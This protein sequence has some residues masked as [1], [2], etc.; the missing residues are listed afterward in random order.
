[1]IS[2]IGVAHV[3]FYLAPNFPNVELQELNDD[4]CGKVWYNLFWLYVMS[5][6]P[7]DKSNWWSPI[8][9]FAAVKSFSINAQITE[10]WCVQNP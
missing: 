5:Y 2:E 8:M 7:I 4:L 6:I 1:M 9:H 10:P 3:Y